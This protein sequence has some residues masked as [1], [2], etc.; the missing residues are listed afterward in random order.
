MGTFLATIDG[1]I[2]LESFTLHWLFFVNLPVGILGVFLV[3]RFVPDSRPGTK[4]HFDL[5]GAI[6]LFVSLCSLLFSLSLIQ[7][8]GFSNP[9]TFILLVVF[10]I[11]LVVFIIHETRTREPMIDLMKFKNQLFTVNLVTGFSTFVV[12][13]IQPAQSHAHG[14]SNHGY[15]PVGSILGAPHLRAHRRHAFREYHPRPH[16][17]PGRR[18]DRHYSAGYRDR[19]R[20]P[21]PFA[22]GAFRVAA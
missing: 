7:S 8:G 21:V 5:P 22:V 6:I 17:R 9:L 13:G 1:G 4:Q 15:R 18:A 14:R 16:H 19:F 20:L 2:L 3:A 10:A 12:S 11:T